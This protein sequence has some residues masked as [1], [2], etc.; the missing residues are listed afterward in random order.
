ML[1]QRAQLSYLLLYFLYKILNNSLSQILKHHTLAQLDWVPQTYPN[2][3]A[4]N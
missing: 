1:N 3:A 2:L 4:E